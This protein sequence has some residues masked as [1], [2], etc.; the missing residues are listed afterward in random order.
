M[1][2]DFSVELKDIFPLY[3]TFVLSVQW[4]GTNGIY[5]KIRCSLNIHDFS[6]KNSEQNCSKDFANPNKTFIRYC[7]K[8][9]SP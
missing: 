3:Q 1:S 5:I 4:N 2:F 9:A 6:K 7:L 8:F